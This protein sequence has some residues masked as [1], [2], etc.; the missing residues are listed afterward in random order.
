MTI[1]TPQLRVNNKAIQLFVNNK[2]ILL[3]SGELHNSSATNLN[4]LDQKFS[5]LRSL[6]LN[7]VIVPLSWELIEP[8]EGVFDFSL[9]EGIIN[10]ARKTD[11][12]LVL[13]WFATWKNGKSCY[14]PEWVKTNTNRF[15]RVQINKGLN[16]NISSPFADEITIA[17]AKAFASTMKFIKG[18]DEKHKTVLMMQLEN[19]VGILGGP[20]DFSDIAEQ[21]FNAP[22][23]ASLLTYLKE[24]KKKLLPKVKSSWK[25]NGYIEKGK[26][27]KVFGDDADE[28]FMAWYLANHIEKVAIAGR[29]QYNIPMFV[30]AWLKQE[31]CQHPGQY[32]SGGPISDMI[33]IYR[34]AAPHIDFTAPDIYTPKFK[35]VC[36]SYTSS[37]NPLFIPET[38]FADNRSAATVFYAFA[39]HNAIGFGP[40][41]IDDVQLTHPLSESYKTLND[42]STLLLNCQ[43]NNRSIGF[44]QQ[45]E[46]DTSTAMLGD[47]KVHMTSNHPLSKVNIPGGG[48]ILMLGYDEFL[49]VGRNYIVEFSTPDSDQVN[50]ELLYVDQG[51]NKNGK[52][53]KTKRL[54]GDETSHGKA[55]VLNQDLMICKVKT[56]R[57]IMPVYHQAEWQF[58]V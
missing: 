23:P 9:V 14:V 35:E 11:L 34:A 24:N 3:L 40:F 36:E 6:N 10:A 29:N 22:V 50:I 12:K 56:N 28:I 1:N 41:A 33:D 48:M 25:K 4:E 8:Q 7:S 15:P 57:A 31:H 19:E 44:Y 17:D 46:K 20:R 27:E 47:L 51:T 37:N 45:F 52:W 21:A 43:A 42:L 30:N 32:P 55:I 38:Y 58:P 26:W 18:Y 49:V 54:N 2:P 39:H 53:V 5:H 13:L 16:T